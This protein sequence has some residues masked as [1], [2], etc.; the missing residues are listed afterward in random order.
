MEYKIADSVIVD[1]KVL[2]KKIK[3]YNSTGRNIGTI[4]KIEKLKNHYLYKVKLL[5]DSFEVWTYERYLIPNTE[6]G[7]LLY[8]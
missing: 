1:W 8:S 3:Y 4:I 7:R 5:D 2:T 6:I